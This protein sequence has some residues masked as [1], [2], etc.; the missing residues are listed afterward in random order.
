MSCKRNNRGINNGE[1]LPE[2]YLWWRLRPHRT[3]NDLAQEARAR[4]REWRWWRRVV[5]V[6]RPVVLTGRKTLATRVWT[7]RKRGAGDARDGDAAVQQFVVQLC[8]V[9][10]SECS[11]VSH[12]VS[13]T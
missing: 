7:R 11:G 4:R 13:P 1:D 10:L 3:E 6:R 8:V 2:A 5:R 9:D 12:R